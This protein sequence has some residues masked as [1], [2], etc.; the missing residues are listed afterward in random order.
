MGYFD[1]LL[2]FIGYYFSLVTIFHRLLFFI[3]YYF[4]LNPCHAEYFYAL[5][6][7]PIYIFLT[8]IENRVDADQLAS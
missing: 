8:R 6:S 7:S 4:S 2:F 1:W 3:G 5:H